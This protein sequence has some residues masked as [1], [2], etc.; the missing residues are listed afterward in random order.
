MIMWYAINSG[1]G[2]GFSVG[3]GGDGRG[4]WHTLA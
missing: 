4:A 1:S 3:C 2:G